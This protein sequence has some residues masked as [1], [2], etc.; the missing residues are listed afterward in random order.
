MS[1][2]SRL[3]NLSKLIVILSLTSCATHDKVEMCLMSSYEMFGDKLIR[4]FRCEEKCCQIRE[5][6][7]DQTISD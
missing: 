5:N 4:T 3:T 6:E 1:L 2:M 7:I